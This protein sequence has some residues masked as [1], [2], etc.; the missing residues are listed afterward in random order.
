MLAKMKT[1]KAWSI[2]QE[3][4]MTVIHVERSM[5]NGGR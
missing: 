3:Q 4:E 1:L 2:L 5:R